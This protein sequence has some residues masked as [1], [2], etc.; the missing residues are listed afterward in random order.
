MPRRGVAHAAAACRSLAPTDWRDCRRGAARSG[1]DDDGIA[2]V[3]DLDM[4][5]EL[6]AEQLV[7]NHRAESLIILVDVQ[8]PARE[9]EAQAEL[10]ARCDAGLPGPLGPGA[11][12]GDQ[13]VA[14]IASQ[15]VEA[16]AGRAVG[17]GRAGGGVVAGLAD[18]DHDL[19]ALDDG[20]VAA[21]LAVAHHLPAA[22]RRAPVQT[23]LLGRLA[24]ASLQRQRPVVVREDRTRHALLGWCAPQHP[25]DKRVLSLSP[26][27][28]R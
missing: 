14:E 27:Y 21:V 25:I 2:R 5:A 1:A 13:R 3:L 10:V 7:P 6:L 15:R 24:P 19:P 4:P 26:L 9:I 12:A 20:K 17:R 11:L 22:H 16:P 18:A 23:R 28:L 8:A